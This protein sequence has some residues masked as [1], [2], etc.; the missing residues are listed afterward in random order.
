MYVCL[1]KFSLEGKAHIC[2]EW[3]GFLHEEIISLD[4]DIQQKLMTLP[5][6]HL[7]NTKLNQDAV[8]LT[9]TWKGLY[10]LCDSGRTA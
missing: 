8:I 2:L 1:R 3:T 7:N 4:L 9:T 5:L 6:T 10:F